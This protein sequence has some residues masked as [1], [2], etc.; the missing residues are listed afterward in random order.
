MELTTY[1]VDVQERACE[2]MCALIRLSGGVPKDSSF[3]KILQSIAHVGE[4]LALYSV[5]S[6]SLYETF[7]VAEIDIHNESFSFCELAPVD[8]EILNLNELMALIN[9]SHY[10]SKKPRAQIEDIYAQTLIYKH[11]FLEGFHVN[12]NRIFGCVHRSEYGAGSSVQRHITLV[13]CDTVTQS[14]FLWNER[15]VTVT[16]KQLMVWRNN[17]CVTTKMPYRQLELLPSNVV[18]HSIGRECGGIRFGDEILYDGP[19]VIV[20]D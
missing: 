11:P 1:N 9:A 15:P 17:N 3:I 10:L 13:F 12:K 19:F 20:L 7:A 8:F 4:F 6:F 16:V 5:Y 2:T 18:S 14:N